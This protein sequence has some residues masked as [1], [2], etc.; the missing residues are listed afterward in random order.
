MN[1]SISKLLL[2]LT[3]VFMVF[4]I[5]LA[6]TAQTTTTGDDRV[7]AGLESIK[8]IYPAGAQGADSGTLPEAAKKIIDWALY[9]AAMI[10]VIF[11]II[12]GYYYITARGNDDQAKQ[13][14]KTLVNALLGLAIVV[15][16]FVIVQ[17]VYQFLVQ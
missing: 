7:Q 17:V 10:A 5:P 2:S 6:V 13:G 15:L 16:S 9:L 12:G 14:R 11:I 4:G 3:L 1:K 8:D